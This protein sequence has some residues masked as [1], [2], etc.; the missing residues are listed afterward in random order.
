[1][2]YRRIAM[3]PAATPSS[4]SF[5]MTENDPAQST[6]T[7]SSETWAFAFITRSNARGRGIVRWSTSRPARYFLDARDPGR[8]RRRIGR[9][10]LHAG[11]GHGADH[12]QH[13]LGRAEERRLDRG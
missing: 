5:L 12:S 9:R 11:P 6:T 1:M 10:D 13:A 4:S 7:P 3:S 2:A 8:V